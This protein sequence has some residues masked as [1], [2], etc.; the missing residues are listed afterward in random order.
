MRWDSQVGQEVGP[1]RQ[2]RRDEWVRTE[3]ATP[4]RTGGYEMDT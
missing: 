3:D 4:D 1:G 2:E